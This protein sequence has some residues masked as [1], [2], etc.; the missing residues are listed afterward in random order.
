MITQ[1]M[2]FLN[3]R[4]IADSTLDINSLPDSDFLTFARLFGR[5]NMSLKEYVQLRDNVKK[6]CNELGYA[7]ELGCCGTNRLIPIKYDKKK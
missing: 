1:N 3:R 7:W 2:K 5:G 4:M 6:R